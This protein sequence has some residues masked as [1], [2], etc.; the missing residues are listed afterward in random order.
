MTAFMA[1]M[2]VFLCVAAF[3]D[4]TS[5]V[6]EWRLDSLN[7]DGYVPDATGGG[8]HLRFGSGCSLTNDPTF[9]TVMAFSGDTNT[10]GASLNAISF[11]GSRSISLWVKR[12]RDDGP[13][14]PSVNKIPYVIARMSG[15]AVNYQNGSAMYSL[16]PKAGVSSYQTVVAPRL[17]WHHLVFVLEK[18]DNQGNYRVCAYCDGVKTF[19]ENVT[20]DVATF[21]E[22]VYLGN[23]N[24]EGAGSRAFFGR[25]SQVMLFDA[26]LQTQA[27]K[28]LY[29]EQMREVSATMLGCWS[30]DAI[31]ESSSERVVR[32]SGEAVARLFADAGV[33][34]TADGVGDSAVDIP[35]T[36]DSSLW[37]RFPHEMT[38]FT[39]GMWCNFSPD[40]A[41]YPTENDNRFPHVYSLGTY[42][43]MCMNGYMLNFK[44]NMGHVYDV[45]TFIDSHD[46]GF[47]CP[48]TCQKGKWSHLGVSSE[49]V[50][51]EDSGLYGVR[52]RIY[53]DGEL[54]ST[55]RWQTVS[56]LSGIYPKNTQLVF[57]NNGIGVNRAF[58][59]MMDEICFFQGVL[60]DGQMRALAAGLPT[61]W[62]GDDFS[63]ASG[64]ACLS[65]RIGDVGAFGNRKSAA[66]TS[67]WSVISTPDGGEDASFDQPAN[68]H[69]NVS[70]PAI[71]R[72]VFRLSVRDSFGRV[73]A[74]DIEVERV[75]EVGESLPQTVCV[76]G[77]ASAS[78][79]VPV[80]LSAVASDEY[81]GD[82][83]NLR[84]SWKVV[85]GPCA[86]RFD[87]AHGKDVT[88][89]FCGAG[90]YS[91]AA[92]VTDGASETVSDPFDVVVSSADEIDLQRGLI[93]YWPFEIG[94]TNFVTGGKYAIDRSGVTW[95][96]GTDGY[97]IRVNGASF[98]YF[99]ANSTLLEEEDPVLETTPIERYRAFS[100]WIYH[101]SSDTN[102]SSHA[103]IVGVPYTLGLW[104]NC[105]GGTNGFS[106]Y[107]QTLKTW[108][109]GNGNVD[110]Y[111]RPAVDPADRWT[112]VYALFDRRTNCL[113]GT[114]EL[115]ID[116]VKQTNMLNHGMGGGRVRSGS[117]GLLQIGGHSNTGATG[118]NGH[119]MDAQGNRLSRTFPGI[120]DEVRMYNRALTEAEIRY[121]ADNPVVGAAITPVVSGEPDGL[122]SVSRKALTVDV[123]VCAPPMFAGEELSYA[124][125]V[126]SGDPS[127]VSFSNPASR[128]TDVKIKSA[129]TYMLQLAVSCGGRTAYSEPIAV[130][131][132]SPG[133][134]VHVK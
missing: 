37:L 4:C 79:Y 22:C 60:D 66:V 104:Y 103:M 2:S 3:A 109:G 99:N 10:W 117:E 11:S 24:I 128:S 49:M 40:L 96:M 86:V 89:T 30:M 5:P 94:Q 67:E 51:D 116:G 21:A 72:Y 23:N 102:N 43:R 119:W 113:N 100:C 18:S 129:G 16:C 58:G 68:V 127:K 44:S 38:G 106:M 87:P 39:F 14:D 80:A 36:S 123:K 25:M 108:N 111:A 112:H 61:V 15:T 63:I 69:A 93:G 59:G 118:N 62:A 75:A 101:D 130:Q 7:A 97:A 82:M 17:E 6:V 74:D 8:N 55:G 107:Q 122:R 115:W 91:I 29:S 81:D 33:R 76:S 54:V 13:L 9:G 19:D 124:W 98:P 88:A 131:V 42:G 78:A 34:L 26:A 125:R 121:L 32:P 83:E 70:L 84:I 77:A 56:A 90:E 64:T 110:V 46:Q 95:E 53:V 85:S 12:E 48:V 45:A 114:S 71:G 65:G 57:G 1:L 35:N 73:A 52:Q 31:D 92:A 126:L 133:L 132:Q 134:V 50:M 28:E 27:V 105:E 41:T 47:E 120:I 20:A